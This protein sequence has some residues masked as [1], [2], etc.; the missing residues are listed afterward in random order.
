MVRQSIPPLVAKDSRLTFLY[1]DMAST[2][3]VTVDLGDPVSSNV[4]TN[5]LSA[6]GDVEEF[7]FIQGTVPQDGNELNVP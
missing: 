1:V 7:N 3:H 6:P 4:P 2:G 5:V